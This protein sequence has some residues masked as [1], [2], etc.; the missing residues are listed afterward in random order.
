MNKKIIII[1]VA[2]LTLGGGAGV[3]FLKPEILPGFIQPAAA[4]NSEAKTAEPEKKL[5][6]TVDADLDVFVVNLLGEG[7][8]RY[9]RTTLSLGVAS[10]E[11][12]EE[13]KKVS[14]PVRHAVIMYLTERRVEELLN[15]EGKNRLRAELQKSINAAI[16]KKVVHH[17]YFKEFLI[18]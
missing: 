6:H 3:Y 16:G 13:I 12:K 1:A 2:V 15:P 14:G 5:E 8:A 17:V 11:E 9:L 4:E 18:Q 10:E 7:P